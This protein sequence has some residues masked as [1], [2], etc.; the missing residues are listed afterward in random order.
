MICAIYARKSNVEDD[1][2]AEAKS[3]AV[4]IADCKAYI[5]KKGWSLSPEHVYVDDNV[6]GVAFGAARP[7][8]AR[9]LLALAPRPPFQALVMTEDSRLGR[10]MTETSYVLKG[11][12]DAGVR[13]FM[14]RDDVERTLTTAMDKVIASLA[15]F[16]SEMEREKISQRTSAAMRSRA[17][18]G[19]IAGGRTFGYRR[20]AGEERVVPE[21]AAVIR[22]IFEEIAASRGLATVAKRLNADGVP[23]PRP[24]RPWSMSGVRAI[25]FRETYRGRLRW[26][27]TRWTRRGGRRIKHDV[28]EAE[29]VTRDA[30]DLRIV[31]EA[32]W[33]A[34]HD[35]MDRTR[36][37][38]LRA[39]GGR[40][41]GRPESGIESKYLLVGFATCE[42][43]AGGMH[44]ARYWGK[45]LCYFCTTHRQRGATVCG[46][47]L[48][49]RLDE[50]HADLADRLER[51]LLAP[52]V[53]EAALARAQEIWT[54]GDD[55]AA[56][57]DRLE[58]EAARLEGEIL[59]GTE[60]VFAGG[61]A[62]ASLGAGLKA[63]ERRL[64]EV[65]ADLRA[66]SDGGD[67]AAYEDVLPEL[68]G[69][70]ADWRDLLGQETA[71]ARQLLRKVFTTRVVLAPQVLP[72]GRFYRWS[73][74]ASYGRLLSGL[75]P[76]NGL[77]AS[78]LLRSA[79]WR[80]IGIGRPPRPARAA[81]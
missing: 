47:A 44:V 72:E 55:A 25:V 30:P 24:G 21:Q 39:M 76:G 10:E 56:E 60:A 57:R 43:C 5:A 1:R 51:D 53:V 17:R 7:A 27:A 66:L 65:R 64:G 4:Q 11:I 50:L 49:A 13:V 52:D 71:H 77:R 2:G 73:V 59:R 80:R 6:S 74:N 40:L 33:Q 45:A 78:N 34:A 58:H 28:P 81:G 32:L 37:T 26:G 62:I 8:L 16:S 31:P 36:A 48:G 20:E 41:L 63:R 12:V 29:W 54:N 42:G 46:N 3:V 22:R 35:R 67:G 75:I 70:L 15:N 38:Y 19:H 18:H 61:G 23:S 9:L 68:K 79:R 69:L 14:A